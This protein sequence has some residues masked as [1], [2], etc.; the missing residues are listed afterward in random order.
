MKA[1]STFSCLCSR[2]TVLLS[3]R[4]AAVLLTFVFLAVGCA[5][6]PVTKKH[7]FVLMSEEQE[8]AIGKEQDPKAVE[9][10]G[11]FNDTKWQDY[12]NQVGQRLAAVCHRPEL[13]YRFK[14]LDSP[15]INA[16]ALPGGYLY[17]FR[18]LLAD[19]NSEAE[20]ATVLGHEL[21]HVTARHAVEQ[22]TKA[23]AYQVLSTVASIF[24]P[25][26]GQFGQLS[27]LLFF[28]IL[29]GYSRQAESQADQL[30]MEYAYKAGYDP[31]G[32]EAFLRT[33]KGMEKSAGKGGFEGFFADHPETADRI[34]AAHEGALK[35]V[36]ADGQKGPVKLIMGE[37]A[38]LTRLDGMPYGPS[39]KE[40]VVTGNIFRH[41][42]MG[43]EIT[44][45]EG[46]EIHNGKSAVVAVEP[47]PEKDHE[48]K[49]HI[50]QLTADDL[51]KRY[52]P[53]EYAKKY[54]QGKFKM[55][56]GAAKEINGLKAYVGQGESSLRRIGT[57]TLQYGILFKGDK[58]FH[59]V[60]F[61][62]PGEFKEVDEKFRKTI[63]SFRGLSREE[64]EKIKPTQVKIYEV[65]AGETLEAIVKNHAAKGQD[66][67]EI[68]IL[69]GLDPKKPDLKPG[70][71]IKLIAAA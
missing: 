40:G 25:Q 53:D 9:E 68:A 41:K 59:V 12:V 14:V 34:K 50:I 61:A 42:E 11:L 62:P 29:M 35:W 70:Q 33:L 21:G 56:S 4:A 26:L 46:W 67:K 27:D 16:F 51:N 1:R 17:I 48:P 47:A 23:Q 3:A 2:F 20:L 39:P 32:A 10:F 30:G 44:F 58:A 52:S 22:Y 66:V 63:E 7:E 43:V 28:G 6:N 45:P 64:A 37:D 31:R 36:S 19:L 13:I 57:V 18:G 49:N 38:Y 55:I 54:A 71:K 8:I 69:N 65:K 5:T 24:I 60:G 15:D